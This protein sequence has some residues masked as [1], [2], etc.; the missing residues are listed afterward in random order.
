VVSHSHAVIEVV[1]K[2]TEALDQRKSTTGVFLDFFKAFDTI[3]HDILFEKLEHC[4][5]RGLALKWLKSYL[6]D[7]FQQVYYA[8]K[9][10]NL[11]PITCGVPQGSILGPLLFLI[12]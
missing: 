1:D 6:T 8:K 11:A 12:H 3:K 7:R 2:I 4:G 5:I 10:S 9:L